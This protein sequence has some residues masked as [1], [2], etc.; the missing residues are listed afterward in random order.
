MEFISEGVLVT[1]D[2][3]ETFR[4]YRLWVNN[5]GGYL[6]INE[7]KNAESVNYQRFL[8]DKNNKYIKSYNNSVISCCFN[9]K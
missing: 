8:K 3:E 1:L 4:S 7:T 2:N 9:P 6:L 5:G